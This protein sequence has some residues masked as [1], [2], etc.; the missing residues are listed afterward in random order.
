MK[1][2]GSYWKLLKKI[3]QF[4]LLWLKLIFDYLFCEMKWVAVLL[5]ENSISFEI[6]FNL[7][8]PNILKEN[9]KK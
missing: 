3:M 1:E 5:R 4:I 8:L 2:T 6:K 9:S 7:K